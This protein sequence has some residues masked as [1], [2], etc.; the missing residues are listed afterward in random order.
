MHDATEVVE[1]VE[2]LTRLVIERVKASEVI[3]DNVRDDLGPV[4]EAVLD[5]VKKVSS[6]IAEGK[7]HLY[8]AQMF[9]YVQCRTLSGCGCLFGPGTATDHVHLDILPHDDGLPRFFPSIPE[10]ANTPPGHACSLYQ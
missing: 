5:Y 9:N 8:D 1:K 3:D 2:E 7:A 6:C 4:V 10:C